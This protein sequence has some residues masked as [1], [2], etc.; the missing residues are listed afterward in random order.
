VYSLQKDSKRR[1][2]ATAAFIF[3]ALRPAF[4]VGPLTSLELFNR[5]F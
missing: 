5:H 3:A 4:D 1:S 2:K